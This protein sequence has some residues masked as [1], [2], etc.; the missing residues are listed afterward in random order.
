MYILGLNADLVFIIYHLE[1]LFPFDFEL[2]LILELTLNAC[3]PR[4]GKNK[5]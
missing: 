1:L 5:I 4:S 3:V 2:C